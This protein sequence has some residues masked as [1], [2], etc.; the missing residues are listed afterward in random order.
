MAWVTFFV[1]VHQ[2]CCL[3]VWVGIATTKWSTFCKYITMVH[4]YA[5]I[6]PNKPTTFSTARSETGYATRA[7]R[8]AAQQMQLGLSECVTCQHTTQNR[9]LKYVLLA[10]SRCKY[11][12]SIVWDNSRTKH[13]PNRTNYSHTHNTTVWYAGWLLVQ[14]LLSRWIFTSR[15]R[16]V[17]FFHPV[18]LCTYVQR[19]VYI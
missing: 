3:C 4:V 2:L 13:W 14:F 8:G 7:L 12:R 19:T 18:A 10:T 16:F 9:I 11:I 6:W 17:V 15:G 1:V 5:C